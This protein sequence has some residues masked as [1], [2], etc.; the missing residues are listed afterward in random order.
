MNNKLKKSV[1]REHSIVFPV[2]FELYILKKDKL[3]LYRAVEGL[4]IAIV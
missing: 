4:H 2:I 3:Y 1:L